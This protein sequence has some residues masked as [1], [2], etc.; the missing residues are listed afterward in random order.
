MKRFIRFERLTCSG[1]VDAFIHRVR[2][3]VRFVRTD[4]S[5]CWYCEVT[6]T[7]CGMRSTFLWYW[8][9]TCAHCASAFV[10]FAT[11]PLNV[12]TIQTEKT[13]TKMSTETR[14][15]LDQGPSLSLSSMGGD[16]RA[17][18]KVRRLP[19]TPHV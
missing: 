17:G 9:P 8:F 6:F 14:M 3:S 12:P 10:F 13:R 16:L 5:N 4:R 2:S 15:I 18:I 11:R 1:I 7:S 19:V